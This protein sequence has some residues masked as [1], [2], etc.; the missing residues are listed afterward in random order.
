LETFDI[1][2]AFTWL[3]VPPAEWPQAPVLTD[4]WNPV[5]TLDAKPL[6]E[7]RVARRNTFPAGIRAA[8]DWE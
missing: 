3:E 7:L 6:E 8:L 4:D 2:R 1:P 5:D